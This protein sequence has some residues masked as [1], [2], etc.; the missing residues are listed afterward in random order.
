MENIR[1]GS[2]RVFRRRQLVV[3]VFDEGAMASVAAAPTASIEDAV[4]LVPSRRGKEKAVYGGRTFTLE[5]HNGDRYR[6]RC[7]VRTCKARL[8]TD[9]Y[10]GRHMVYRFRQ[11]DEEPHKS[12]TRERAT[13]KGL[14]SYKQQ[15]T[16]LL[17]LLLTQLFPL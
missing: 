10:D 1:K 3:S 14:A 9:V 12:V 4:R 5:Q 2:R 16:T 17:L 11:H 15:V 7:D 8:T 6:W 13:R